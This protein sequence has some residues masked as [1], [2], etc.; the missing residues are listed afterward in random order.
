MNKDRKIVIGITAFVLALVAL[1]VAPGWSDPVEA[2]DAESP[3][4]TTATRQPEPKNLS[5]TVSGTIA[6]HQRQ[7]SPA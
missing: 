2:D 6:H 3:C 7:W 5:G 1:I 4:K